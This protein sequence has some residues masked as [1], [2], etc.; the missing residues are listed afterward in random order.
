[1]SQTLIKKHN[2]IGGEILVQKTEAAERNDKSSNKK[3]FEVLR[4]KNQNNHEIKFTLLRNRGEK[5]KERKTDLFSEEQM[6]DKFVCKFINRFY[7]FN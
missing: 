7:K 6:K 1:M 2:N 4:E 5:S 3:D